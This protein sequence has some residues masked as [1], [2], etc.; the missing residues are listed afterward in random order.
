MQ[1]KLASP[2]MRWP[3]VALGGVILS[4]V[5]AG[6]ARATLIVVRIDGDS[7]A[8]RYRSGDAVLTVQRRI[9]R[10]IRRGDVVVCQLPA[11]RPGPGGYLG[12]IV[13]RVTA[14][15]GDSVAR[16]GPAGTLRTQVV[17]PGRI[18]IQGD[19]QHSY[20]SRAFGTIPLD[21]VLGRVVLR[22]TPP[23]RGS[24][25]SSAPAARCRR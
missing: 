17:E 6:L 22:L 2:D 18:Y 21:Y 4:A 14:V 5:L 7:M 10:T 13:K 12:Y 25:G 20:D 15:E 24:A 19:G 3:G 1:R 11:W 23:G 16:S 8:P 9:A